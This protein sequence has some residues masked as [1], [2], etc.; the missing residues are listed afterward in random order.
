[1]DLLARNLGI[2]LQWIFD[3][4]NGRASEIDLLNRYRQLRG[5]NAHAMVLECGG[6]RGTI[7]AEVQIVASD[8]QRAA[9]FSQLIQNFLHE[10]I[11]APAADESVVRAE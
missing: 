8:P 11:A 5:R 1:M 2:P 9:I 7:Q 4:F 3:L 6:R 10:L